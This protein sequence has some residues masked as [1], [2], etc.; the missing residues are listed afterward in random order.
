MDLKDK[1]I[2]IIGMALSGISAAKLCLKKQA[3][4]IVY[5]GKTKEQLVESIKLFDDI[6][7]KFIFGQFDN[8]ILNNLDLII[9]SPGVPT[10][11]PFVKKAYEIGIPVW[12]EIE[13]SYRLCNAP[14]V[15]ITGTNGK[16]T[17]TTL[18]GN[19]VKAYYEDTFVVGN[20]GIPFSS[21]IED[22]NEESKIIAEISS[23]QLETIDKFAPKVSAI[24]NIT[25][26]HL[27]R[28]KTFEN[29]INA[30]LRICENQ[31]KDNYCI[32]NYDNENCRNLSDK[33]KC[34]IIYFS[35]NPINCTGVYLKN[36][37]V[38]S[39]ISGEEIQVISTDLLGENNVENI[40]AAIAISI[41]MDIP[42][43]IICKVISG[44]RGVA[45]RVEY[46][47]S[48]NGIKYFNDS[49]ATNED[50]AI[51][52]IKLMKSNT[53]LIGGGMDKGGSFDKWIQSFNGKVKG[54]ILFGET[55]S[56]IES[57]ARENGFNLV[58]QVNNLKEAV[59]KAN[60]LACDGEN[61][62]LSPACA[63]WD[64]F[65][66]YEERGDLFKHYVNELLINSKL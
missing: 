50:A 51:N 31:Q 59:D 65:K 16:T 66:N 39:N 56:I 49:K 11:L 60:M 57:T 54:L 13:F 15:A 4:V 43:K 18:V 48:I 44:F 24:L 23:F 28:H 9:I 41:C 21:I 37:Y 64:M 58:Y 34:N 30:K 26:D 27:N 53:I 19:I 46:V 1:N 8:S 42:I 35:K 3:N 38:C 17:T 33:I 7:P 20:I 62:L 52:G 22:I 61:V 2:L 10:D 36:E 45:H 14:I 29:Y 5:D 32:I 55:A 12:S 25:P 47:A 40:M 63:S 6:K